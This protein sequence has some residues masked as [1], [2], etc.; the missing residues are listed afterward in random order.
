MDSSDVADYLNRFWIKLGVGADFNL[1]EKLYIRPSFLYG[2][3]F[4]TKD[5]NDFRETYDATAFYH[6]LDV[7]GEWRITVMRAC[8]WLVCLLE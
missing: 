4:G 8:C 2:I 5:S 1:T 7:R 6:G 3:N